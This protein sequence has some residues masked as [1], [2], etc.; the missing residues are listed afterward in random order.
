MKTKYKLAIGLVIAILGSLI[1]GGNI[2]LWLVCMIVAV[3][4]FRIV[5]TIVV[6]L[7]IFVL[8]YVFIFGLFFWIITL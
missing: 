3:L 6:A 5:L 1:F 2:L 7:V 8:V 4:A